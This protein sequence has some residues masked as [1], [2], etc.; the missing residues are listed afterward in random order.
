LNSNDLSLRLNSAD[1]T[2]PTPKSSNN[3]TVTSLGKSGRSKQ[4]LPFNAIRYIAFGLKNQ[5]EIRR[6]IAE[7][8]RIKNEAIRQAFIDQENIRLEAERQLKMER[9][10][11]ELTEMKKIRVKVKKGKENK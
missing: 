10:K 9:D 2:T 4:P 3:K 8:E 11:A 7:E 1:K 6:K 5:V